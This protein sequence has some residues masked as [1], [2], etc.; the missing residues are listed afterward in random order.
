MH[1][2]SWF[3]EGKAST[4]QQ[5]FSKHLLCALGKVLCEAKACEDEEIGAPL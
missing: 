5:V 4:K 1:L 3:L 2:E